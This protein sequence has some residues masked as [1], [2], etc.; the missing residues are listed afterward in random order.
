MYGYRDTAG[1][2][3]YHSLAPMYYRGASAA[4][5]VYDITHAASFQRAKKWIVELRQNVTNASLIIALVG[6][7]ADLAEDRTVSEEEAKEYASELDLLYME[8][9][10]K[11]NVNVEELFNTVAERCV[12]G[13]YSWRVCD[14]GVYVLLVCSGIPSQLDKRLSACG[15]RTFMLT[16]SIYINTLSL[17]VPCRIPKTSPSPPQQQGVQLHQQPTTIAQRSSCCQ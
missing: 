8:T 13:G 15:W 17:S 6:N 5:V 4:V 7:K 12:F 10:A 11:E 2:E 3:R 16:R 9:S 1:Q 14:L